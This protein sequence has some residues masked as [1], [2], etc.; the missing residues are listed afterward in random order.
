MTIQ[1][2]WDSLRQNWSSRPP[3]DYV[4]AF[5]SVEQALGQCLPAN[6]KFFLMESNGGETLGPLPRIRL[7]GL[8]ELSV[9]QPSAVLEIASCG[10]DAY[11]FDLRVNRDGA[12]YP[13]VK[14]NLGEPDESQLR[15]VSRHFGE[16]LEK[17]ASGEQ[18]EWRARIDIPASSTESPSLHLSDRPEGVV[19]IGQAWEAIGNCWSPNPAVNDQTEFD[20]VEKALGHRLPADYKWFLMRSNGGEALEPLERMRFYG[21][22][23]LLPRREDGQPLDVLEIAT[24]DSDGYAFDLAVHRDNARY[25]VMRYSLGERDRAYIEPVSRHF[26]EFLALIASGE[27]L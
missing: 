3:I 15:R 2:T 17:I 23:E 20:R 21:L 10:P 8:E 6:Y 7:Y 27:E 18:L 26:A 19:K 24:N 14:Y 5:D 16:F 11:G 1:D 12:Q 9:G 4:A 22:Q 25:P 13:V